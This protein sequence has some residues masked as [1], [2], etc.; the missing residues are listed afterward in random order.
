MG[1]RPKLNHTKQVASLNPL[2]RRYSFYHFNDKQ[3]LKTLLE[4]KKLLIMNYFSFSH[5]F[6]SHSDNFMVLGRFAPKPLPPL[7]VSPSRRFP[8]VVLPRSFRRPPPS[9]F[10]SSRIT[11]KSNVKLNCTIELN[12]VQISLIGS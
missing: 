10:P 4:K 2:L 7:V 6:S 3:L 9:R 1:L 11:P 8:Q 5:M 12:L